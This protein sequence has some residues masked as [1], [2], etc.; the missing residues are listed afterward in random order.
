MDMKLLSALVVVLMVT[1]CSTMTPVEMSPD[2]LHDQISTGDILHEGDK[3]KIVTTDGKTHQFKVS[4]IT[5]ASIIG[6]DI[7]VPIADIVAIET[8]E[9]SGGKT[10]ALVG[11]VGGLFYLLAAIAASITIGF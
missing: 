8:K 10:A 3:V 5:D 2:Q 11:G 7:E 1:G 6:D 4:A 9:F